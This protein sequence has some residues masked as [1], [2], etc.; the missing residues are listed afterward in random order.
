MVGSCDCRCS[1]PILN[2][3]EP[4]IPGSTGYIFARLRPK[5]KLSRYEWHSISVGQL[6]HKP[7]VIAAFWPDAVVDVRHN[8]SSFFINQTVEQHDRIHAA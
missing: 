6:S 8:D 4:R 5:R 1:I 2:L 3:I 7:F